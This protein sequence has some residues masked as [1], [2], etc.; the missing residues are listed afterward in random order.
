MGLANFPASWFPVAG[1]EARSTEATRT[2]GASGLERSVLWL[3]H[4]E[5]SPDAVVEG[6]VLD[7]DPLLEVA[8]LVLGLLLPRALRSCGP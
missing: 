1:D 8:I 2:L 3:D 4:T 5:A 6:V 7:R